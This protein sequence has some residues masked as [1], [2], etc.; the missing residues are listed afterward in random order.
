MARKRKSLF[1]CACDCF[2][3]TLECRMVARSDD[4]N[5]DLTDEETAEECMYILETIDFA[6]YEDSE[7]RE[8]KKACKYIIKKWQQRS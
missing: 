2:G 7:V 1:N 5:R 3:G 6:G 4:M 8:I